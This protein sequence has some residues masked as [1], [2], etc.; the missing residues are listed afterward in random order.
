MTAL[1]LLALLAAAGCGSEQTGDRDRAS[2][3]NG[4]GKPLTINVTVGPSFEPLVGT[5]WTV[6]GLTSPG[7]TEDVP[8][9]AEKAA[10]FTLGKD[11]TL[12]GSLGCNRFTARAEVTGGVLTLGPVAGTKML[13]DGGKGELEQHLLKVLAGKVAYALNGPVIT[14]TGPDNTG[15]KA[16]AG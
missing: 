3:K 11:G 6:T 15:L 4:D 10:H 8:A 16:T 5:V 2:D 7:T 1:L 12:S 9:G 13:C 14:L